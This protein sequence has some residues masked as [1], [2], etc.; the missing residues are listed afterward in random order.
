MARNASG[1]WWFGRLTMAAFDAWLINLDRDADRLAHMTAQCAGVG[2]AFTRFPALG[3]DLNDDLR[4]FFYNDAGRPHAPLRPGE[5]GCYGSHLAIMAKVVAA[6]RPGLVMEDDLRLSPGFARLDA[7][8]AAAPADW[9]FLRLSNTP[10]SPCRQ[11]GATADGPIVEY[12][13]VPNN[14]GAYLVSPEGAARFLAA[15]A[16]RL[17]PI[18]EDLRREWEH[19]CPS[20]GPLNPPAVSNIFASSIDAMGGR[21]NAPARARFDA[22]RKRLG[23]EPKW[24]WRMRRW[25]VRGSARAVMRSV[26]LS[27][28]KHL[29]FNGRSPASC[30]IQD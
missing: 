2:V 3:P 26:M 20:Y 1:A 14:T 21:G 8:I 4:P 15:Y 12:W 17:R 11:V 25:G 7:L 10:K 30:L 27:I 24:R 18:D 9:G 6:G 19:G 16:R 13:R 29:K 28:G 5:I 22:A 23:G